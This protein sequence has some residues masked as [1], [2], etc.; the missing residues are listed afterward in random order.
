MRHCRPSLFFAVALLVVGAQSSAQTQSNATPSKQD[1]DQ[2]DAPLKLIKA[3]VVQYPAEARQKD[4]EGKFVVVSIIVD[5]NGRVSSAK[6]LSGPPELFQAALDSV[7]QW[8]YEPPT[9]PPV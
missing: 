9:H 2:Q 4:L 1:N 8:Q 5:A 6:P 3:P 7:K